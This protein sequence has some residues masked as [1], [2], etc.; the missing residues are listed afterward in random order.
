MPGYPPQQ[1]GYGQPGYPPQQGYPGSQQPGYGQP[2]Y[3]PQQG[4]P[5]AQ[6]P[7]YG[8]PPQSVGGFAPQ[9]QYGGGEDPSVKGF[10]FSDESVRRGFIRKVYSILMVSLWWIE[11]P[12]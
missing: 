8:Y 1:P 10:D 9:G 12:I 11:E 3:P 7:G 5:G 6:Q 2:G 4:Y